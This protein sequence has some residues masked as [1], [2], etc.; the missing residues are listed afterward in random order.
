MKIKRGRRLLA[1]VLSGTMLMATGI[2]ASAMYVSDYRMVG[3]V[4]VTA[5]IGFTGYDA[6]AQ[7]SAS[8]N[9]DSYFDMVAF[10]TS[11]TKDWNGVSYER[12]YYQLERHFGSPVNAVKGSIRVDS[13][14]GS[15][16][17]QLDTR[18]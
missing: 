9:V 12:S 3:S 14:D 17:F 7:I 13:P 15:Y 6:Y 10:T 2:V 11:G 18:D 8:S 16:E 4:G 5:E 1:A